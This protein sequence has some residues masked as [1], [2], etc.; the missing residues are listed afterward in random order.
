MALVP[1][2]QYGLVQYGL[3]PYG[4]YDFPLN[5]GYIPGE[6]PRMRIRSRTN[7]GG[8]GLWIENQQLKQQIPGHFPR[9]R[10]KTNTGE[11][12][13]MQQTKFPTWASKVRIR[14]RSNEKAHPWV[15]YEEANISKEDKA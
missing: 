11:W 10:I 4:R 3:Y 12:V 13:Y 1:Y 14:A 6:Q 8:I 15:L 2:V 7:D 5:S 9:I